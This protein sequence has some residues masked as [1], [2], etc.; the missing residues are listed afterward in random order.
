MRSVGL[1][2]SG[3]D[4]LAN[5]LRCLQ[6]GLKIDQRMYHSEKWEKTQTDFQAGTNYDPP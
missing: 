5:T 3:W 4:R 1:Q 6:W 2:T